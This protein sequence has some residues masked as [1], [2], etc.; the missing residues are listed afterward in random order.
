[1]SGVLRGFAPA[2]YHLYAS[3]KTPARHRERSGEAGGLVRPCSSKKL[4]IYG[5][6]TYPAPTTFYVVYGWA[7]FEGKHLPFYVFGVGYIVQNNILQMNVAVQ[8]HGIKNNPQSGLILT[9]NHA[10]Y[11]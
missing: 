9:C 6:E 7:L 8:V 10:L 5:L 3:T 4:L 2:E 11:I 1:M